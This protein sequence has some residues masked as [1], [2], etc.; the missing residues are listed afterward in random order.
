MQLMWLNSFSQAK[1]ALGKA[2]CKGPHRAQAEKIM[3]GEFLRKNLGDVAFGA[4]GDNT[5]IS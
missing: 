3:Q 5:L 4:D 1:A 2:C